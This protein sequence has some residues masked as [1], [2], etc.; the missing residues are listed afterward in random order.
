MHRGVSWVSMK[1]NLLRDMQSVES[2]GVKTD[3][4]TEDCV[5]AGTEETN[6]REPSAEVYVTE[7]EIGAEDRVR[8]LEDC[9]IGDEDCVT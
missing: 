9:V 4:E 6:G 2:Q 1:G 5:T 7:T 8:R 3:T